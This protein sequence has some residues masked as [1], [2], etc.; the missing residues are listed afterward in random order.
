[1]SKRR[2]KRMQAREKRKADKKAGINKPSG[3]SKYG[4]K[5]RHVE[6]ARGYSKRKT[7]PFY[8]PPSELQSHNNE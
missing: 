6:I 5:N 4:K 8:M 1:M 2:T 7:S 3:K